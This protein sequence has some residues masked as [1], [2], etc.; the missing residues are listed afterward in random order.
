MDTAA[1]AEEAQPADTFTVQLVLS[2]LTS[3]SVGS[4]IAPIL[5]DTDAL[6]VI[7]SSLV[8]REERTRRYALACVYNLVSSTER[9]LQRRRAMLL[10]ALTSGGVQSAL[11]DT[12]RHGTAQDAEYA[13]TTLNYMLNRRSELARHAV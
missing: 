6:R 12:A 5:R 10:D 9:R 2:C 8:D 4:G 7:V 13:Q 11:R 1:E 3:M